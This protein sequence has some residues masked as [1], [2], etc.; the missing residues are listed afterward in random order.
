[1]DRSA[2]WLARGRAHSPTVLLSEHMGFEVTMSEPRSVH[3]TFSPP[4][5]VSSCCEDAADDLEQD[6]PC[7][8]TKARLDGNPER[9]RQVWDEFCAK[10]DPNAFAMND[11]VAEIGASLAAITLPPVARAALEEQLNLAPGSLTNGSVQVVRMR[12][13]RMEAEVVVMDPVQRCMRS[14]YVRLIGPNELGELARVFELLKGW[15]PTPKTR[16]ETT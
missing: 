12:A 9:C 5:G 4:K 1:M 8:P 14:A 3:T 7:G 10:Q 15:G 2:D 6:E 13:R 11:E 16:R